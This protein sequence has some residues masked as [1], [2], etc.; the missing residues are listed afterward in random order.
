MVNN[1]DKT[2]IVEQII[3]LSADPENKGKSFKLLRNLLM[4]ETNDGKLYKIALLIKRDT[5]WQL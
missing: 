3:E 2:K 5:I 1:T 4:A